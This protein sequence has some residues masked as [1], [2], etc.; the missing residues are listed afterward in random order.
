MEKQVIRYNMVALI[1][2]QF[3]FTKLENM[4]LRKSFV[5]VRGCYSLMMHTFSPCQMYTE[6]ICKQ[7]CCTNIPVIQSNGETGVKCIN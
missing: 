7:F 6:A 3:T 4:V 5:F 1:A 2:H